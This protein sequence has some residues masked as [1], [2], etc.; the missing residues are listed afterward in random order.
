[1]AEWGR[2]YA[3]LH[4]SPKWRAASKPARSLW[5]TAF[6]WCID[7]EASEGVVPEHM[8]RALDGA[9]SEAACLV[10]V[11]LWETVDGGWIFHDWLVYQRSREQIEADRAAATERQRR[12]R[13]RRRESHTGNGVTNGVSDGVSHAARG[14]ESRGEEREE[15]SSLLAA[16]AD[17]PA[18]PSRRKPERPLPDG[19]E[20]TDGHT[21]YATEHRLN[22]TREAQ[23]FRDHAQANDR[24]ARDWDAAFRMWLS[25]AA[26]R[27]PAT[28]PGQPK[29]QLPW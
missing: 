2:L 21:Q 26:E 20:P 3:T 18:R 24:R 23:R 13:E 12:A 29:D 16:D 25:K 27:T 5:T 19:W 6:S 4:S 8:L 7:Q 28:R 15:T 1:M 22:L 17:A 14:E 10:K 9:P 11:G